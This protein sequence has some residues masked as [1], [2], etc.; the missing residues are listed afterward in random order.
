MNIQEYY[1]TIQEDSELVF[2]T[3]I[4]RGAAIALVKLHNLG[5][6]HLNV[7]AENFVYTEIAKNEN[8]MENCKLTGLDKIFNQ[9][10]PDN[11]EYGHFQEIVKEVVYTN[12]NIV[13]SDCCICLNRIENNNFGILPCN[14]VFHY[15][16][17]SSWIGGVNTICPLCKLE[18]RNLIS[19][20]LLALPVCN[21][22]NYDDIPPMDKISSFLNG[23]SFEEHGIGGHNEK[24][25]SSHVGHEDGVGHEGHEDGVG[26]EGH[27]DGV[28]HEGHEDGVG[29]EGHEDGVGHEGHEDGVGHEGHEDGVGHEG[30]EDGVGHE[31]HEDGGGDSPDHDRHEHE[32]SHG[33]QRHERSRRRSFLSE[34]F[35]GCGGGD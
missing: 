9:N 23:R 20:N 35:R 18:Q 1:E 5:Y 16:C 12:G 22:H 26:H 6:I 33:V 30:H 7:K 13:L 25:E 14:H 21:Q 34:C 31:G 2:L 32:V 27:E 11:E 28:G 3:K 24:G 19:R 15:E 29:H 17:I 4:I 10:D 8:E